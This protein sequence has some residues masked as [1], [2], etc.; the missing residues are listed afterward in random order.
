MQ[1]TEGTAI[2]ASCG[3][4][5]YTLC[6]YSSISQSYGPSVTTGIP[7]S[8]L[9]RKYTT[10]FYKRRNHFKYWLHR[11]QGKESNGVK[12]SHISDI[13]QDLERHFE[14]ANYDNIRTSLK[15]L[16][17]KRFYNNTY[18][19]QKELTGY[20][21]LNLTRRQE[22]RLVR[23]FIQIQQPFADHAQS[24]VNMLYYSYL[25][26][27][28]SEILKWEDVAESMRVLKSVTKTRYLD[29]IWREICLQVGFPFIRTV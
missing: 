25:I 19:I 27:K 15:R 5:Q 23:M 13:R 14:D 21:L 18:H 2:C 17:L 20:A 10:C 29:N 3:A 6:E 1:T 11:I 22:D 7:T 9:P 16:G 24:R 8:H 28:F 26:R 12:G 4:F